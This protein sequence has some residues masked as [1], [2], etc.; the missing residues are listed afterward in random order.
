MGGF[1]PIFDAHDEWIENFVDSFR[2]ELGEIVSVAQVRVAST[3]R[4][5]LA[6]DGE[7]VRRTAGNQAALRSIDTLFMQEMERAGFDGLRRA[8]VAQFPGQLQFFEQIVEQISA[9][10]KRPLTVEWTGADRDVLASFQLSA[11]DGLSAVVETAATA[12]RGRALYSVGALE[13]GDLVGTIA[14]TFGRAT[15]EAA[16]LAATST[17]MF[18][19]TAADRGFAQIEN[20]LKPGAVRYRYDG[21]RDKLIRPFCLRMLKRTREKPMTR[22]QISKLSNGQLPNVFVTCGGYNC[23]HQWLITEIED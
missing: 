15:G 8:F 5:R 10:L 11:S 22:A 18:Y 9:T 12:A 4:A 21:P 17:T 19:R 16:T 3:L 14:R 20:G 23:R 7:S 2:R 1:A 6:M 13:F